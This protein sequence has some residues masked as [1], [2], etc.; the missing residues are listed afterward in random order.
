MID[1]PEVKRQKLD[2]PQTYQCEY[3]LPKKNKRCRMLR[4]KQNKYCSE[5]MIH[6]TS[7]SKKRIPC[8]LNPNHTIWEKDLTSHLEKCNARPKEDHDPW[9]VENT[10]HILR[11][12][13]EI[14]FTDGEEHDESYCRELVDKIHFDPLE[15]KIFEHEGLVQQLEEKTNQKHIIQQSSLIGNLKRLGLLSSDIFYM[16][17][18]CGKGELSR[19]VN[20]CVLHDSSGSVENYGFGLI[21]RGTN[22]LK[23]D[24]KIIQESEPFQVKPIIK[25][26]KIDIMHLHVDKFMEDIHPKDV[27]AISKHLCGAA[28]D[29]TLKSLLNSN[30][31][32]DGKFGG[33]LIAMCCRHVCF[34]DEFLPQSKEYLSSLGFNSL[35][36]IKALK[37]MVSWGVN[38]DVD[39]RDSV[40]SGLSSKQRYD[41]GIKARRIID[42]SRVYALKTI[43]GIDYNIEIFWYVDTNVT[44]ENVCLSITRKQSN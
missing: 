28:T 23:A 19:Y 13:T 26:S 4:K 1:I 11:N 27:V 37:K 5:H 44:K 35:Q 2:K 15:K 31:F 36:S 30:L 16:E 29:L 17:F 3:I 8:P 12:S 39:S 32:K 43:L 14:T 22:R 33:M 20:Q 34:E 6:D 40:D 9:Y 24:N 7:S 42:E 25:R 21:D 10:N 38:L 18:G 41:Y